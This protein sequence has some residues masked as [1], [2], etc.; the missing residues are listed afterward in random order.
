MANDNEVEIKYKSSYKS[1]NAFESCYDTFLKMS[2][3]FGEILMEH[4]N[5]KSK[6]RLLVSDNSKL[7]EE[8]KTLNS[9]SEE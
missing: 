7:T 2:N 4:E 8:L 6:N 5:L 9:L 1:S 3:K